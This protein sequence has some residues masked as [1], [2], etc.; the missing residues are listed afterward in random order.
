MAGPP[1][2]SSRERPFSVADVVRLAARTLDALGLVWLEGE[3]TQV[4]KP[5]SGHLYFALRDKDCVLSAVMWG[6]D[7]QRMKFRI[8]PA[9]RLRVRGRL[10]VYDRDG[11]M[12]LYAD[13][14]EP[15]GLG[16]EALALD[17]LKQKLAAEGIFAPEKKRRLP[18]FPRR[19][20]LRRPP[21]RRR[22][23]RTGR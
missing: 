16:A 3:V 11:K 22:S 9:Q 14:A 17:Q 2:A 7:S 18:R 4:T 10:G 19:P 15:A 8:E 21:K 5:S 23:L 20:L 13:F 1:V 6:R 12:Q